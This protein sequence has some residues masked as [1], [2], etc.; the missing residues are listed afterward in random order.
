MNNVI[1]T[2]GM[3]QNPISHPPI[4]CCLDMFGAAALALQIARTLNGARRAL[5]TAED[6]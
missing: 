2:T 3:K 5:I 1:H 6:A 4:A